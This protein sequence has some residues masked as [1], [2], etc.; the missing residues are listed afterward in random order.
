[1]KK[2]K[3]EELNKKFEKLSPTDKIRYNLGHLKQLVTVGW[4]SSYM[5]GVFIIIMFFL[6]PTIY[7]I[8]TRWE[9]FLTAFLLGIF[10]VII[11]LV[12]VFKVI[13]K[14]QKELDKFLNEKSKKK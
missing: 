9:L 14:N 5:F 11:S 2:D 3:I 7:S 8:F 6:L 13:I 12:V 10:L 1:M 4:L